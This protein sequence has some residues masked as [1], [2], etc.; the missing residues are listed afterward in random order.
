MWITGL[1]ATADLLRADPC[2]SDALPAR[3]RVDPNVAPW[4]ELT[5]L[6]RIGE[7]TAR[8]I[9]RYRAS[10]RDSTAIDPSRAF[11]NAGDLARVRGIGPITVHRI[12]PYLQFD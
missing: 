9:V 3:C 4:F 12:A 11:S 10:V 5:V 8:T 6:P 2:Q 1:W 7:T